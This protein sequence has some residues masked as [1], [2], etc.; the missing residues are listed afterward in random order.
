MGRG[1]LLVDVFHM[2]VQHKTMIRGIHK[3]LIVNKQSEIA[4]RSS[5][6]HKLIQIH[7]TRNNES[8][9]VDSIIGR[10]SSI[11]ILAVVIP[12]VYL[13]SARNDV[14]ASVEYKPKV[15]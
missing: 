11:D 10:R 9:K 5:N 2:M 13:A 14:A 8:E 15:S 12:S 7:Q 4:V 6:R 1:R 3:Q